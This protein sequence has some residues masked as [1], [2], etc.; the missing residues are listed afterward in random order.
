MNTSIEKKVVKDAYA[1]KCV[2]TLDGVAAGRVFLYVLYNDLHQE[3]F[4]LL[5]DLFVEE[6]FRSQG[7]GRQLVEAALE[8]AKKEKCYKVICTSRYGREELH[9]WYKK[10]GFVDHGTEFRIDF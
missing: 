2:A 6:H 1:V 10:I 4:G 8:A 5:E 7:V 3:P 9:A